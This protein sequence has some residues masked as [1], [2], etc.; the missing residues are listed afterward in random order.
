MSQA[1][2]FLL[3]LALLTIFISCTKEDH[4][5]SGDKLLHRVVSDNDSLISATFYYDAQ[6]RLIKMVDS[7]RYGHQ[8]E[9]SIDYNG[10]GKPEKL[11]TLYHSPSNIVNFSVI[12]SLVY[13]GGKVVRKYQRWPY[14]PHPAATFLT[15]HYVYDAGGRLIRHYGGQTPDLTGDAW[16]TKF[17]YD[18][19][20][21]I[22][23]MEEQDYNF[24]PITK[25]LSYN[26]ELNPYHN[27]GLILYFIKGDNL[28]LGKHNKTKV[29]SQEP[30]A[31]T[32]TIDYAY[33]HDREG[34]L[35]KM[36]I[37][38]SQVGTADST[39]SF[40]FLYK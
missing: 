9:T 11:T 12:D 1:R 19:D 29:V 39:S 36:I 40:V 5:N 3:V 37:I 27:T 25:T 23:K 31:Q 14:S 15:N 26:S 8:W 13:E 34:L 35:R 2:V 24:D 4:P 18:G 6:K 10:I 17:S 7:I 28:F 22:F 38:R 20:D 32:L 21:N 16:M 33:E 30:N